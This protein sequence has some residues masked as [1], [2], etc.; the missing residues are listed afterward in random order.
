MPDPELSIKH[1]LILAIGLNVVERPR[2]LSR[3]AGADEHNVV[4]VLYR[5]Q[6]QRL[7]EYK[8]RKNQFA[9]GTNLTR[10][11]LTP[12]GKALYEELTRD[13]DA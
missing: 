5:L 7:I 3:D 2:N 10:I 12:K 13:R 6:K 9:P 1:R 8:T 4:H 11:Q